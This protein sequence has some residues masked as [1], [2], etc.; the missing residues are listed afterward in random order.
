MWIDVT[1]TTSK[2]PLMKYVPRR[3]L[4]KKKIIGKTNWTHGF[5]GGKKLYILPNRSL[6]LL[7]AL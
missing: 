3:V 7:I 1:P 6:F 5:Q 4:K 2:K